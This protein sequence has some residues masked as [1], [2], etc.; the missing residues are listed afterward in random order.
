LQTVADLEAPIVLMHIRGTPKT[1]QK[2]TDYQ[3][4][5]AEICDFLQQRATAA[6]AAGVAPDKIA[7]DPGIGFAKTFEQNL[8]ILRHLPQVAALG[9]P[10]LVGVS[11]KGFLGHL[12]NQPDPQK[13]VWGTAAANCAAIA[14]GVD[15]IRVHDVAEMKDVAQVADAVWRHL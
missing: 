6:I 8:E 3:N 1:M 2:L 7:L 14:G 4:L 12:L 15:I 5:M 10:L 11:R 13:R 9:Y